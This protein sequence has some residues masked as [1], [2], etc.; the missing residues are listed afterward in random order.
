[1]QP[2][3]GLELT[4]MKSIF[5]LA[6]ISTFCLSGCLEEEDDGLQQEEFE[7]LLEEKGILE[8]ELEEAYLELDEYDL[9]FETYDE[10]EA[11]ARSADEKDVQLDELRKAKE[12]TEE[13]MRELRKKFDAYQ[14]KYEAKVRS[15][16]FGEKYAVLEVAGRTL[17]NVEI[18]GIT[19]TGVKVRHASGFATLNSET[20]PAEWTKRFFLRSEEEVAERARELALFL[21]PPPVQVPSGE[22]GAAEP[23]LSAFKQG[24][25]DKQKERDELD[26][27]QSRIE[28]ALVSISGSGGEGTGFFVQDGITTYLYTAAH[29]LDGNSQLKIV[30]A[31]GRERKSF[32]D[33]EVAKGVNL[34]RLAVSE[35]VDHVL[36]VQPQGEVPVLGIAVASLGFLSGVNSVSLELGKLRKVN[37]DSY[38]GTS[39]LIRMSSGAPVVTSEGNVLAILT[40]PMA[41]RNDVWKGASSSTRSHSKRFACRIDVPI[42]WEKASLGSFVG[43][44]EKMERFDRVTRLLLS[45]AVIPPKSDGLALNSK[46]GG[47]Q[48]VR[49]VLQD[50]RQLNVVTQILELN[51][52]LSQKRMGMSESDVGRKY[53]SIYA[54]AQSNA[55]EQSMSSHT[56][57]SFH[58]ADAEV[59]IQH[60]SKARK[61]MEQ[62]IRG[63]G[64]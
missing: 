19:E 48:T 15:K 53:R 28:G 3:S 32:G 59:S 62:A 37:A 13:K 27:L 47:D 7:F 21:N 39:S 58:M 40:E 38:E 57:S 49:D 42:V 60:R 30:D 10:V 2:Y 6:L 4:L 1:M 34:V 43:A 18:N 12:A 11:K 20:A 56:F 31:T 8:S 54:T 35:P 23:P 14:K 17:E 29:V 63:L 52:E 25:I 41:V 45:L 36:T 16:A 50:N 9:K 24:R 64:K 44:R 46:A 5:S 51:R 55:A 33:L 26:S 22:V 61:M